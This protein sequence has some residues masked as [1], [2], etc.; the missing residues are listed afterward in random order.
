MAS[1][2]K[3]AASVARSRRSPT[4]RRRELGVVL[5]GLRTRAGMTVE[6]VA[7]SLLVSPSKISRLETGQRGASPR[8]IRDL[9]NLYQVADSAQREQ[10]ALLAR[11]GKQ[12]GWWQTGWP[13]ATFVG[14]E[15]EATAI[16]DF[17]SDVIPGLLQT[18]D[19]ARA[20]MRAAVPPL[21]A[22]E[23][24]QHVAARQARQA[25]LHRPD[26]PTLRAVI[27]EAV[28]HRR[29]A[30]Q[31]VMRK[32][33][34]S[35]LEASEL[36]HVRLQVLEFAAGQHPAA[37]STFIILDYSV[38]SLPST[39]YVETLVGNLYLERDAELQAY[40]LVFER[41]SDMALQ[42]SKTVAFLEHLFGH[43]S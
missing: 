4:L 39:V 16:S 32:Q 40:R 36:P 15:A 31:E 5:R 19:Y 13:Y 11:E 14:L 25:I 30:S 41:L 23:I 34:L 27:D 22:E 17:E 38:R 28:F 3:N 7:E 21:T 26:A 10:L 12:Q 18:E 24:E 29:A 1:V 2:G 20:I 42:P 43:Y 35:L 9:C 8:D 6:Q 37:E 33:I